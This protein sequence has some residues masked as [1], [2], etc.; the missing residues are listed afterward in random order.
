MLPVEGRDPSYCD[1]QAF[2]LSLYSHFGGNVNT[3]PV[4]LG[5]W[6]LGSNPK[7][8]CIQLSLLLSMPGGYVM[9]P[10]PCLS[11]PI[12][13]WAAPSTSTQIS[14]GEAD[15][16]AWVHLQWYLFPVLPWP[17]VRPAGGKYNCPL[18][19]PCSSGPLEMALPAA[20]TSRGLT[21]GVGQGC[22]L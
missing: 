5:S 10:L 12:F 3:I 6:L 13:Q 22:K 20:R 9:F 17:V 2:I 19:L 11:F 8:L 16:S 7:S 4:K 21:R 1:A 14:P 15:P 18:G